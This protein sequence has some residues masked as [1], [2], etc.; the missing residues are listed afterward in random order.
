[1]KLTITAK[2]T[3]NCLSPALT[4]LRKHGSL[5]LGVFTIPAAIR[6]HS[7]SEETKQV[8]AGLEVVFKSRFLDQI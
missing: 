3:I 8:S 7:D 5:L 1:M 6:E 2:F 4:A